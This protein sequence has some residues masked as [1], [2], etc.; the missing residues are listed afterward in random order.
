VKT[1]TT[2]Q[3]IQKAIAVHGKDTYDYSKV[4]YVNSRIKVCITCKKHGDFWQAPNAHC[5]GKGCP[6]CANSRRGPHC[7]DLLGKKFGKLTVIEFLG[8]KY[9]TGIKGSCWKC[10]CDCGNILNVAGS[11]LVSRNVVQCI[12]CREGIGRTSFISGGYRSINVEKGTET[13]YVVKPQTQKSNR[14]REH[15][16]KT[17]TSSYRYL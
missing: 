12:K 5:G 10:R 8:T 9:I 1:S 3:F 2:E 14:I 13:L 15:Y 6:L 16:G 11:Q 17:S 7:Y 4:E